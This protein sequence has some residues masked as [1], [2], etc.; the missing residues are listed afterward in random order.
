MLVD[1][2]GESRSV[3]IGRFVRL[4]GTSA[5]NTSRTRLCNLN[6]THFG[7]EVLQLGDWTVALSSGVE[8]VVESMADR[9]RVHGR[10]CNQYL[11]RNFQARAGSG[12]R[13]RD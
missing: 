12:Q 11:Q 8:Y 4:R 1:G 9:G 2:N 7:G 13:V 5:Q 3:S 10:A 6:A